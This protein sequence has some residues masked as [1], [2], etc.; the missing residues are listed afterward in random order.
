[1]KKLILLVWFM[2]AGLVNAQTYLER[3]D[4]AYVFPD[5]VCVSC[6]GSVW[7]NPMNPAGDPPTQGDSQAYLLAY[8]QCNQDTC[9]YTREFRFCNYGFNIPSNAI[10]DSF[11]VHI[12]EGASANNAVKDTVIQLMKNHTPVGN[13]YAYPYPW[14]V[15]QGVY[16]PTGLYGTT[17]TA[18]EVN[19]PGFGLI[20]RAKN[21]SADTVSAFI[22]GSHID[23]YYTTANG[24]FSQTSEQNTISIY[25][26]PTRDILTIQNAQ[27][28]K[29]DYSVYDIT[30][31]LLQTGS[32]MKKKEV[33][34]RE[35]AK[36]VYFIQLQSQQ[37]LVS[38]KF[39]KQ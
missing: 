4:S 1:M 13:N 22:S 36:G 35:F 24:I 19:D 16:Y 32:F 37:G 34:V 20:I 25:P 18:Q 6:N 38:K 7:Q 27:S 26:N 29:T 39:V 5:S 15:N 17:W 11:T 10:I 21:V 30:G 9:Y 12:Y 14:Q 31:R 3:A 28:D 2:W 23:I 33:D 8:N